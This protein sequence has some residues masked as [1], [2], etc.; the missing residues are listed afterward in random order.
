MSWLPFDGVDKVF[1]PSPARQPDGMHVI[2]GHAKRAVACE[3]ACSLAS[4]CAPAVK[5]KLAAARARATAGDL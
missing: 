2:H 3:V 5:V 1:T 4:H